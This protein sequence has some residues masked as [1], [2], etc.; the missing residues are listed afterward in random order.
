MTPIIHVHAYGADRVL[1]VRV[2]G[3]YYDGTTAIA[4]FD[5][6]DGTGDLWG[7]VTSCLPDSNLGPNEVL[8]KT[9][10]ENV[11]LREPLLASGMFTDTGRRIESGFVELEVW[12]LVQEPPMCAEGDHVND[13]NPG[14]PICRTCDDDPNVAALYPNTTTTTEEN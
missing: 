2:V 8:V 4:A 9:Y 5:I 12:T 7:H 3:T 10:S 6:G 1:E 13:D 14:R 11:P